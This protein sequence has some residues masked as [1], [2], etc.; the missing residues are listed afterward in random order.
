MTGKMQVKVNVKVN[1]QWCKTIAQEVEVLKFNSQCVQFLFLFLCLAT[2]VFSVPITELDTLL[3]N[4]VEFSVEVN[5]LR[6]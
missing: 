1:L 5:M 3:G 2:K 6:C 4:R